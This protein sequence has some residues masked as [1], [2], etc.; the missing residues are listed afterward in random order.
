[1]RW[2]RAIALSLR[3]AGWERVLRDRISHAYRCHYYRKGRASVCVEALAHSSARVTVARL[4]PRGQD[5]YEWVAAFHSGS[6]VP[7]ILE[8][9]RR[10]HRG[11]RLDIKERVA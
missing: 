9:A 7:L 4:G 6:P 5:G 1:M 3:R 11:Y 10:A 2:Q 8:A